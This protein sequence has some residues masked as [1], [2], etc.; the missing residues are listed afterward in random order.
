MVG[1]H[2]LG[3]GLGQLA[4]E[5]D[6]G[7]RFAVGPSAG[8][9]RDALR[10]GGA[11][12]DPPDGRREHRGLG[13][14]WPDAGRP[15]VRPSHRMLARRCPQAAHAGTLR[16]REQR[17]RGRLTGRLHPA[18]GASRRVRRVD[19]AASRATG[20]PAVAPLHRWPAEGPRA[21]SRGVMPH[22]HC[23]HQRAPDQRPHPGPR[24]PPRRPRRPAAR[25]QAAARG[26]H[27][28]PRS[29]SRPGRGGP[30]GQP[31]GLPDHGLREVQVRRGPAGQ[32][33]A[34]QGVH[35]GIKEMKYRPKIGPGDFDTKTRQVAKFLDDGHKV[36]ITIMFRGRE[37]FHPELGKRILDR[38]AEQMGDAAKVESEPRLDGRNMVMVLAPDKRAKQSAAAK[39]HPGQERGAGRRSEE[40]RPRRRPTAEADGDEPRATGPTVSH[41]R[42]GRQAAG[43][44]GAAA[45]RGAA[46]RTGGRRSGTRKGEAMPKMKTDRGRPSGSRSPAPAACAAA[47]VPVA[48]AAKE[49]ER[50]HAPPR[51]RDRLRSRRR[52]ARSSGCSA[53]RHPSAQVRIAAASG[54]HG[55]ALPPARRTAATRRRPGTLDA[56]AMAPPQ[57]A[58]H[59]RSTH[60]QSQA[61]RPR[62]QAPP[63]RP[64]AGEGL[65]RQQ[66]PELPRRQRAAHALDAVRLPRPPGPQGRLPQA[67]DPADQRGRPPERH[68][69]QPVHRRPAPGRGRGRPQGAGRPGRDRRRGLRRPG[70]SRRGGPD[71]GAV[72]EAAS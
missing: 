47:S 55:W 11:E 22:S 35:V 48:H 6:L 12:P 61:L 4:P 46:G 68:E 26:A 53:S 28:R 10:R 14:C 30:H 54:R 32:G 3:R 45:T 5:L 67:V 25:D 57:Q 44:H 39:G 51:P 37:V 49:D 43:P 23:H 19:A 60:G 71:V 50:A 52:V 64:R 40:E 2:D 29:R 20:P 13:G 42:A 33:V 17:K 65:L 38:I 34:A 9:V 58:R 1:H 7:C 18:T 63:R 56:A 59:E 24:G 15:A 62:Q 8:L 66:E 70:R 16:A 41:G 69:L 72:A 31:A 36:K 21:R 27:H